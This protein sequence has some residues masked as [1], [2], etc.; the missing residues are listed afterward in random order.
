[1]RC[2][3][4]RTWKPQDIQQEKP[5]S[6]CKQCGRE[7]YGYIPRDRFCPLCRIWLRRDRR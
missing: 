7:L 3:P 2:D 6:W 1:M 5:L 4:I